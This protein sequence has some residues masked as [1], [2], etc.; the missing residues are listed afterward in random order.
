MPYSPMKIISKPSSAIHRLMNV[1]YTDRNYFQARSSYLYEPECLI[2]LQQLFASH[3]QSSIWLEM[4]HPQIIFKL[5]TSSYSYV[6][7]FINQ[8]KL[9]PSHLQLFT[10]SE[11]LLAILIIVFKPHPAI[12]RLQKVFLTNRNYFQV[13]SRHPHSAE[14]LF[15]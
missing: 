2:Y 1:L 14:Y 4:H 11:M 7:N 13:L 10:I 15:Y 12:Y 8:Q 9:I 3:L 5:H 6:Q